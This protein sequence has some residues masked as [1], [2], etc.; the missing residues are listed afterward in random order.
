MEP[1]HVKEALSFFDRVHLF[2]IQNKRDESLQHEIEGI[3]NMVEDITI[4]S[5]RQTSKF[6]FS[7]LCVSYIMFMLYCS[8]RVEGVCILNIAYFLILLVRKYLQI[9]F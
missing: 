5:K 3:I 8:S 2:A 7:L 1:V 6:F 9:M 4:R